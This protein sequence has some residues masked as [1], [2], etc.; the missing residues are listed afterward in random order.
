[1][2]PKFQDVT[3]S[4]RPKVLCAYMHRQTIVA[5]PS[6]SQTQ[7]RAWSRSGMSAR[8]APARAWPACMRHPQMCSAYLRHPSMR[9]GPP[10]HVRSCSCI[11]RFAS[12]RLWWGFLLSFFYK[13]NNFLIRS[14]F[15]V[16]F[17]PSCFFYDE[18]YNTRPIMS[19]F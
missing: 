3:Y 10:V 5:I 17:S 13:Y 12:G 19:M 6:H 2:G 7:K 14:P 1:M 11:Q 4:E 9:P 16:L 18:S 15:L 8:L